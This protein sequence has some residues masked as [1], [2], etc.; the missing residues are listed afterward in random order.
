MHGPWRRGRSTLLK[1]LLPSW[2]LLVI[3]IYN[4]RNFLGMVCLRI[5]LHVL[6]W[7]GPLMMLMASSMITW[8]RHN[9]VLLVWMAVLWS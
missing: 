7:W 6:L 1:G 4:G 2:L 9:S 3:I 5:F 8:R